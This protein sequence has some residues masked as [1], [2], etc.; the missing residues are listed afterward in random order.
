MKPE[1]R[2][3]GATLGQWNGKRR[4][5][6]PLDP[7]LGAV[8]LDCLTADPEKTGAVLQ[9]QENQSKTNGEVLEHLPS[10]AYGACV[11]RE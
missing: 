5:L 8:L 4:L 6:P 2:D 9:P 3:D 7:L 10:L 11:R 1:S